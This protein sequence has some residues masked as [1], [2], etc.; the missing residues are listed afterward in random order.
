VSGSH[1]YGHYT[2]LAAHLPISATYLGHKMVI[3]TA[4]LHVIQRPM[5]MCLQVP[6]KLHRH[7]HLQSRNHRH[8][9]YHPHNL[10]RLGTS[11]ATAG[12]YTT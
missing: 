5:S 9:S 12:I 4:G 6:R 3:V 2:E 8:P 10:N 11:T 7:I 1:A